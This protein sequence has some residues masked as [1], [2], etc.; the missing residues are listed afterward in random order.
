[1]S[2][3]DPLEE[4]G[5]GLPTGWLTFLFT[6]IEGSTRLVQEIGTDLYGDLQAQH[7]R[8][9]REA[10]AMHGGR[11]FGTEGDAHFFV[12]PSAASAVK[13]AVQA[14]RRLAAYQWPPEAA[15]RVRMG[16]H[17]GKPAVRDGN[18]V[19]VEL[20]RVARIAASGHGGQVL[21][22]QATRDGAQPNFPEV[23]FTSLGLHRLKDLADPVRIYQVQ[24]DGL[25]QSFPAIRT[26]DTRPKRLPAQLTS[27]IGREREIR[28]VA[29]LLE[30][31]RLVTLAG[32]GGSGK[33]RLAVL[34]ADRVLPYFD[35]GVFFVPLAP[36]R[37]T[38]MVPSTIAGVLGVKEGPDLPVVMALEEHL[39]DRRL[40]LVLDNFEHLLPVASVV[41]RL[42]RA[43]SQVKVLATSRALLRIYGERDYVVAPLPIPRPHE[44]SVPEVESS[45]A[46]QLFLDRAAMARP[47]F[48]LS[49]DSARAVAEICR[50]LD[51][52]PLAIELAAAR[53]R[54]LSPGELL[55]RL[56]R[57]LALE[58]GAR[59]LPERQRTLRATIDWSHQLLDVDEAHLFAQLSI[60]A[61]GWTRQAAEQICDEGLGVQ[62]LDGLEALMDHSLVQRVMPGHDE[63]RFDMLEMIREYARE[64]LDASN[65]TDDLARRHARYF[66]ELV[67][68]AE[69]HVTGP[70]ADRWLDTLRLETDNYRSVLRWAMDRGDLPSLDIGLRMAASLWRFWQQTGAL[71][72]A[73][74][75]LEDLL[76]RGTDPSLRSARAKALIAAGGIAYWQTDLGRAR[77]LYE[78]AVELYRGLGDRR[79]MADA[80]NNLAPI[81][82]MTGDVP[83]ARRLAA[84][85]R[86]LWQELGDHWQAALATLT[87]G[88][89]SLLEG[90]YEQAL[91]YFEEFVPVVRARGD[92]F[93]LISGL[94][95]MAQAQHFLGRFEQARQ[96]FGEA[97]R[98][99]LEANDLASVTIALDPLSNLE[100]AAG[101]HDRAVRLWA[102]S[103]A[104][105]QQIG[106]GAPAEVMRVSNPSA[107]ATLAMGEV[108]VGRAWAEGWAMTPEE[109][110][111]YATREPAPGRTQIEP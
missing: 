98:L 41:S 69:P 23:E 25:V 51:G 50:R 65:E 96:N 58:G 13:A 82:M 44:T 15:I 55:R 78:E 53:I 79:G 40:L 76:E 90:G 91:S 29:E 47:G 88:M 57:R 27:F 101:D 92:R 67:Q 38:E 73:R 42:L 64:R 12:F 59:D 71:R 86:D 18:Y 26:I 95:S 63:L 5:S 80:L 24:A 54:I 34:V 2:G 6:D 39:R 83:L 104:I 19:G 46:V 85:A 45:P 110:V 89:S 9:L 28:E 103:E 62:V 17:T 22:S 97:L 66:L 93:W 108:A 35:D 111:R 107:A 48:A 21:I 60:F 14:Q 43:A 10:V 75:W 33:T 36:V 105:K 3:A 20:N 99:A 11:E 87:L 61:G 16:L 81:P 1:V 52:L 84:Q 77:D 31:D 56:G 7:S 94:T 4:Y 8:L 100:G 49:V 70:E 68:D 109:T 72:E 102:A 106:G 32:P 37:D 74:Q 30:R